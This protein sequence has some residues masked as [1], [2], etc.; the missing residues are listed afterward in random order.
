MAEGRGVERIVRSCSVSEAVD[1]GDDGRIAVAR[2]ESMR[3]PATPSVK[4]T[5]DDL[6]PFPDDGKRREIID[7][8][9]SPPLREVFAPPF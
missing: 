2:G 1:A 3:P 9:C 4:F 6:L 7:G 5:Y 8:D